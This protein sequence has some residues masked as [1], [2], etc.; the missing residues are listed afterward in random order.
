MSYALEQNGGASGACGCGR[1]SFILRVAEN[2][3]EDNANSDNAN[4][5][6]T[7]KHCSASGKRLSFYDVPCKICRKYSPK[8]SV[9]IVIADLSAQFSPAS[10]KALEDTL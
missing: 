10:L 8:A 5:S 9:V 2:R 7:T 4:D 6:V 1:S 3:Y